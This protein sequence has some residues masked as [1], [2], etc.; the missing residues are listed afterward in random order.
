V[1]KVNAHDVIAR[2]RDGAVHTAAEIEWL[3]AGFV[4][5]RIPDYQMAA[6]LMA[7]YLRGLN[8]SEMLALTAAMNASGRVL[9]L[10]GLPRPI[11]DKHSTGGVGDKTTLVLAPLVAACGL[12]VA[13]MSGRGLGHTGGTLDKLESIPGVRV[14]LSPQEF[15]DQVR[16]IGLAVMAQSADV[17]PADRLL[18]ALRDVTATVDSLPLIASS[19]MCKKLATGADAI[20]LD[21]KTGGG[22]LMRETAQA[23]DLARAMV[24]LGRGAGRR[25]AALVTDMDGP[26][27]CAIGNALEVR[28]ALETLHGRGPRDLT[29]LCLTL[30]GHMLALGERAASPE[31]GMD[32]ARRAL[33]DGTA[34]H[35]MHRF[36]AAQ[37]GPERLGGDDLPVAP[38]TV[39]AAAP[40]G[41]IVQRVDALALGMLARDMGAGR[42]TKTDVIDPAVGLVVHRKAGDPVRAGEALLTLHLARTDG[43]EDLA[44]RSLAAFAISATPPPARPL[45]HAVV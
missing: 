36:I 26:L 44:A 3:I 17:V 14:D 38:V 13:K 35:R 16:R 21:V 12:P 34:L 28:E 43:Q 24:A 22:A 4:D 31:Q 2:K 42:A 33:E 19:I 27:G 32:A 39:D 10:A 11:V 5:G 6:W 20:V 15:R 37:G 23:L 25:M 41:G 29:E 30:A 7:A 18:Y 8:E 9:D 40:R 1:H 45:V